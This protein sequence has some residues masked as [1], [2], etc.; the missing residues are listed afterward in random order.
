M[1]QHISNYFNLIAQMAQYIEDGN[2]GMADKL[3][4][5]AERE[6]S[7]HK[8]EEY[9]DDNTPIDM[10]YGENKN[11]G[12]INTIFEE[13]APNLF[14]TKNGRKAIKEYVNLMKDDKNLA[15][16]YMFYN[17]IMK[18][19][20][21]LNS[22]EFVKESVEFIK[23]I[24]K[25]TLIE[26]NNKLLSL[27][28]KYNINENIDIDDEKI[29]LFENCEYLILNKKKLSNLSTYLNCINNIGLY[30]E[31]HSSKETINETTKIEDIDKMISEFNRKYSTTL[32][33]EESA[34]VKDI[35]DNRSSDKLQKK[36][37][38]LIHSKMNVLIWSIIC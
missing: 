6:Y 12:I 32:N 17:T 4:E 23:N 16:Q 35:M 11:F 37:I 34:L 13:A 30:V 38:Y 14:K 27:I 24:D 25:N 21:L 31:N 26:S 5:E 33:E 10:L 29:K 18:N 22:T 19:G 2:T 3:K 8:D 36:K 9:N 28:K 7:L 1:N 20:T 15:K